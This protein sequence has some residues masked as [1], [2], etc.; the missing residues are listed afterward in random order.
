MIYNLAIT[1][2]KQVAK[3][4]ELIEE[5]LYKTMGG[6]HQQIAARNSAPNTI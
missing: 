1:Y 5:I 3:Y 4:L 6:T 2:F